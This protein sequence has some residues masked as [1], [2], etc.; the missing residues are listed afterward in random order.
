MV[1]IRGRELAVP[2]LLLITLVVVLASA[3]VLA[4]STSTL[5]FSAYNSAWDGTSTLRD[6]AHSQDSE[7]VVAL[8]TAHYANVSADRTTAIILSPDTAYSQREA[9]RVRAFVRR[10]GTLVIAEDFGSHSNQLLAAI[11]AQ[12]RIDGRLLR[13]E[14][15][16][17]RSPNMPVATAVRSNRTVTQG[18]EQLTLNHGTVVQPHGATPLVNSSE[19][20]YLDANENGELDETEQLGSYPVA[21]TES[22]GDGR[23]VVVSDPSVFINTMLDRPGNT[24]FVRNL[25][26]NT[27]TVLLDYSHVQS[28]PPLI[29]VQQAIQR[30]AGLQ[31]LVGLLGIGGIAVLFAPTAGLR[32]FRSTL[33]TWRRRPDS[34][35]RDIPLPT[36]NQLQRGLHA[37]YPQWDEDSIRHIITRSLK[38]EDSQDTREDTHE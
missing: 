14:R 29:V 4:A 28:L 21:T 3:L 22:V 8:Q 5:A 17:Y 37:R 23:V 31:I 16:N 36:Q 9:A 10:G 30:S 7:S 20:G 19:Y 18:V 32:R 13:D 34:S 6:I 27:E 25:V 2:Q 33:R 1:S 26:A 11:G 24:A 38:R 35:L 12:A 15:Y